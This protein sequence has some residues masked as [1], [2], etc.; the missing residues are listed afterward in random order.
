MIFTHNIR[1][2][3]PCPFYPVQ[4]GHVCH[5]T[6]GSQVR[7]DYL[8]MPPCDDVRSL[9]HKMHTTEDNVLSVTFGCLLREFQRVSPKVSKFDHILLLVMMAQ[10]KQTPSHGL[11]CRS[12]PPV[13]FI[14]G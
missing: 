12:Y 1:D 3:F 8:L 13:E 6:A 7:E 2:I 11:F 9:G 4:I 5:G 10:D 14:G